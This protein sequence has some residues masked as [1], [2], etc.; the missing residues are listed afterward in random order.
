MAE[1]AAETN[2]YISHVANVSAIAVGLAHVIS[3]YENAKTLRRLGK[4]I[5]QLRSHQLNQMIAKLEAIY[6]SIRLLDIN[7]LDLGSARHLML[8]LK[9]LRSHWLRSVRDELSAMANPNDSRFQKWFRP[10]ANLN[11]INEKLQEQEGMCQLA[12]LAIE[13]EMF[14]A[15]MLNETIG[16]SEIILPDLKA[17]LKEVA[18]LFKERQRWAEALG[19]ERAPNYFEEL[20]KNLEVQELDSEK[21]IKSVS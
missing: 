14:L 2:K 5:D 8:D 17:Q 21:S 20:E 19:E 7:K 9:E 1:T 13:L 16:Y 4:S 12:Q 11:Q 10:K 18:E 6:E 3:N 15:T